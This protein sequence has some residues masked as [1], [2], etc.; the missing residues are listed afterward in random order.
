[1]NIFIWGENLRCKWTN[2]KW[3]ILWTSPLFGTRRGL[4]KTRQM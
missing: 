4:K 2:Q 3:G 1:M